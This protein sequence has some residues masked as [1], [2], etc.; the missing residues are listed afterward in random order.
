MPAA[1]RVV[2][3]QYVVIGR[4][5]PWRRI[6]RNEE[7]SVWPLAGLAARYSAGLGNA[8]LPLWPVSLKPSPT[9]YLN[10]LGIMAD[11]SGHGDLVV[12]APAAS[13]RRRREDE[14]AVKSR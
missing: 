8:C 14:I 3:T 11:N 5:E 6:T 12:K 2:A 13:L 10:S 4:A 9:L 1:Q 7:T